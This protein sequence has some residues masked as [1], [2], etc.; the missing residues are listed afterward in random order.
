MLLVAF[1]VWLCLAMAM[2]RLH[3][4]HRPRLFWILI[5]A[6]VPILGWLTL[7]WGP[8][9]GVGAFALGLWLLF[10]GPF[11]PLRRRRA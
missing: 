5:V 1:G 4:H 3:M 2:P 9:A 7:Y 6:G 11:D 10:R 8:T